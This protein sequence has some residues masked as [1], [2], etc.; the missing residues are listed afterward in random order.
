[1]RAIPGDKVLY[2]K[3]DKEYLGLVQSTFEDKAMASVSLAGV[4]NVINV[5]N[6]FNDILVEDGMLSIE[7]DEDSSIEMDVNNRTLVITT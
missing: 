3:D 1:M 4:G 5:E 7:L 6:D 2:T